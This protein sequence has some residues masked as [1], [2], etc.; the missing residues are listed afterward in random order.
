MHLS[1]LTSLAIFSALVIARPYDTEGELAKRATT[2][3]GATC[4]A[5]CAAGGA[6]GGF[7]GQDVSSTATNSLV[8]VLGVAVSTLISSAQATP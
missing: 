5:E 7:C 8:D 1:V 6:A 2:C 3:E 4:N